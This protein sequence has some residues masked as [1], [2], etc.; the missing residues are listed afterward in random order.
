MD[1]Y[2]SL[3]HTKWESKYHVVSASPLAARRHCLA[4]RPNRCCRNSGRRP[5]RC[6][7]CGG[8]AS[9]GPRASTRATAVA[10]CAD[11]APSWWT[12]PR[13][14]A[15]AGEPNPTCARRRAWRCLLGGACESLPG[16]TAGVSP[17]TRWA[18]AVRPRGRARPFA[19]RRRPVRWCGGKLVARRRCRR[20]GAWR[21]ARMTIPA[22]AWRSLRKRPPASSI[23]TRRR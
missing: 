7:L 21:V 12:T 9:R 3:S 4:A 16:A 8:P 23:A 14:P 18:A 5:T 22:F 19:R 11:A 1:D 20:G 15:A 10:R 2:E 6:A 17:A 13:S